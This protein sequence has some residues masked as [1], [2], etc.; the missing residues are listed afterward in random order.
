[1]ENGDDYAAVRKPDKEREINNAVEERETEHRV[2]YAR[3]LTRFRGRPGRVK[4][5]GVGV[6]EYQNGERE[7]K[8]VHA[9]PP[10]RAHQRVSCIYVP[11]EVKER[12]KPAKPRST[13]HCALEPRDCLT[14]SIYRF[15]K[16]ECTKHPSS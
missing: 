2:P 4:V 13:R 11:V 8:A 12:E 14:T 6:G 10:E 1:M 7:Y 16:H 15:S 9:Q 5:V 3:S